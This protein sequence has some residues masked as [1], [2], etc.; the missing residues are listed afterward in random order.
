MN[1]DKKMPQGGNQDSKPGSKPDFDQKKPQSNDREIGK[2]HG[3][4][5]K[6]KQTPV[7]PDATKETNAKP[8]GARNGG[9]NEDGLDDQNELD[10]DDDRVTQ[11][12]PSRGSEPRSK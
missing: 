10:D 3:F 4:E 2:E 8:Q 9:K 6:D 1:N 12:S 11:R 7:K 5:N